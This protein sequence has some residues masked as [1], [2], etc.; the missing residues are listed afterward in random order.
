MT[1]DV[2]CSHL[3]GKLKLS[4]AYCAAAEQLAFWKYPRICDLEE[5]HGVDLCSSYL[6]QIAAKE[7][8]HSISESRSQ[9]LLSGIS[10]AKFFPY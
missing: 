9:D 3:N 10:E 8:V 5:R 6:H 1:S 2:S 7:F 4:I